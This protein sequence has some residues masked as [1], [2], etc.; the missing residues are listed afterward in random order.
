M[1]VK[2][3]VYFIFLLMPEVDMSDEIKQ[4]RD[5]PSQ[6]FQ[7]ALRELF[8]KQNY[9]QFGQ[10]C[11]KL[12]NESLVKTVNDLYLLSFYSHDDD[13]SDFYHKCFLSIENPEKSMVTDAFNIAIN[14]RDIYTAKKLKMKY[15]Q[16]QLPNPPDIIQKEI[17]D[18]KKKVLSINKEKHNVFFQDEFEFSD[19]AEIVVFFDPKCHFSNNLMK[20]V[21]S[22]QYFKKNF[23]NYS[24]WIQVPNA[25]LSYDSLLAWKLKHP[26][27]KVVSAAN[28][29][30]FKA[31]DLRAIP[32]IYFMEDGK[33]MKE[34]RGWPQEGRGEE[35]EQAIKKTFKEN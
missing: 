21:E 32:V 14:K 4:H 19:G 22:N 10:E 8:A 12:N 1:V 31:F 23:S 24:T 30:D 29:T 2:I 11:E 9:H 18:K 13:I 16:Y 5:L 34:I 28:R 35:L 27:F 26:S 3:I 25:S 17:D 20:S 6:E 33:V 7:V 15:Q